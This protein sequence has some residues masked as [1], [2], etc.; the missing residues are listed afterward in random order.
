GVGL[1]AIDAV[2][3]AASAKPLAA[4]VLARYK[5]TA[6]GEWALETVSLD[7]RAFA[8]GNAVSHGLDADAVDGVGDAIARVTGNDL[9]RVAKRYF[10]RFDVALVMPRN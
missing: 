6:R 8:I 10:Q 1:A 5:E 7:E 4:S 2:V 9:Q 3:K